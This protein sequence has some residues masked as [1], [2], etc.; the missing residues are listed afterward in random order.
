[1]YAGARMLRNGRGAT[2]RVRL[3]N[4]DEGDYLVIETAMS[5]LGHS[6]HVSKSWKLGEKL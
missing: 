1:V 2:V 6:V 5:L 4:F 3:G